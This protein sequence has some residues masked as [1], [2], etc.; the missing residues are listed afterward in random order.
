MKRQFLVLISEPHP[1]VSGRRDVSE[2]IPGL[3]SRSALGSGALRRAKE[4]RRGQPSGHQNLDTPRHRAVGG[5]HPR[6]QAVYISG[7]LKHGII[8]GR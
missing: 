2:T 5:G 6:S 8:P 1:G 4:S 3:S 7:Q